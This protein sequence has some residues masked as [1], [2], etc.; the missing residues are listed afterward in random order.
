[1]KARLLLAAASLLAALVLAP[2]VSAGINP[3]SAGLQVALR[4]WGVYL[5][6]IDA[7]AGPQTARGVRA[8][9]RRAGIPVTGIAG[10][11]T[12]R[13]LGR[14][15]QPLYGRRQMHRGMVGWDVSVLQ[16][17]LSRRGSPTGIIDGYFGAETSRA[18]RR[19][20]RRHG[21][22]ADA[23]AGPMTRRALGGG[24][25][26]GVVSRPRGVKA[27]IN[28]WSGQYGMSARFVRALAW[29]ESG[30]QPHIVSS[31]G[32]RGVMQVTPATRNY[33]QTVLL[34]RPV[35]RTV[36]GNIEIGVVY[37]R[38]LL[39]SFH[40]NRRLALAA[41]NQGPASVRRNGLFR[42]T[43]R[44]VANVLASVGRV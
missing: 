11:R 33:V 17:M 18:L 42:E 30:F 12:R 13:A 7:I 5:G 36:D 26:A 40:G 20:Q 2:S 19:F 23:V 8:F 44:F 28:Y 16:F 37:L 6:P 21:L 22:T 9:Q 41:Y 14:L 39:R 34:G 24:P 38:H 3:Q 29:I 43:R 15:G 4:A 1:M 31:A 27:K 35:P 10:I 32:A 25:A